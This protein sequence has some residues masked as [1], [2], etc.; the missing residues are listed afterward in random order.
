MIF[1]FTR[2]FR[3]DRPILPSDG[4]AIQTITSAWRTGRRHLKTLS[5]TCGHRERLLSS[6]IFHS[7]DHGEFDPILNECPLST[8]P[9]QR[10][11][12]D[13]GVSLTPY[14]PLSCVV[15][16]KFPLFPSPPSFHH[17]LHFQFFHICLTFSPPSCHYLLSFQFLSSPI[18]SLFHP[19][20][21]HHPPPLIPVITC[22]PSFQG[23]FPFKIITPPL[24]STVP[25]SH[26]F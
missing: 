13:N 16:F 1:L 4:D 11:T 14:A 7:P 24:P 18:P 19:L 2:L 12:L 9:I 22:S 17:I 23:L 20:K 15:P 25:Y 3:I 21:S 6:L 26:P 5:L 10:L 8:D